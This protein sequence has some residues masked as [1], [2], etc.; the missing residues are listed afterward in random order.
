[1][2]EPEPTDPPSALDKREG[3]SLAKVWEIVQ[4]YGRPRYKPNRM[5][6]RPGR[7][8]GAHLGLSAAPAWAGP[9]PRESV[10]VQQLSPDQHEL[11][12]SLAQRLGAIHGVQAVALGGSH[13]RGRARPESDIDLYL[14]YSEAAP[15]SIQRLRE[16][17]EAVND[18][19]GPVVT[20]LY[21]WGRWVN[22]GTWLTI[23]RQRVD[24]V[25]RNLEHVERV[26]A[27]AEA[28][29]YELDY[30]Q[31]PPFGFFSAAYLG[32]I[33]V[34]IPLFDPGGRLDVLKRRVADYPEAL[35]RA[36]V[37]DY[38]WAADM[39]LAAFAPK[40][41]ARSGA[42]ETAA[43]LARAVNQLLL[44]LFA[45]NRKYLMD[46]KTALAEVAEFGRVPREFAPR[47]QQTLA[48]LGESPTELAGAVE[49]IAQLFRE[50]AAL[51]D[52]LYQTRFTL[53]R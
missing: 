29:R 32:E 1:M 22:G 27:G 26:I 51:T 4:Y 52:G 23:R 8:T 35:R 5:L 13:A 25:Y 37:Q 42:Y 33:A 6:Q 18:T 15:F 41:A 39:G 40:F 10:P 11:V 19:H 48:H 3:I 28:G 2:I 12:T 16:L 46:D 24:F 7:A 34:A 36:V 45:L 50:T 14:L 31:Q 30:A 49:R 21:G 17:A 20:D 47:V 43:C 53:P 38:L 44:V 9:T